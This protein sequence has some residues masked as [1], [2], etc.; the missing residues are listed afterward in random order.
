[1]TRE[2]RVSRAMV[3]GVIGVVLISAL[4]LTVGL[5]AGRVNGGDGTSL[6]GGVSTGLITVLPWAIVLMVW[7]GYRQM[8]ELGQRRTQLASAVAFVAVMLLAGTSYPL[9]QALKWPALPGFAYWLAGWAVFGV[10]T[11]TMAV[12]DK[13]GGRAE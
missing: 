4:G 10:V 2:H 13:R 6:L 8:D 7:R 1:M 12:A 3:G 5:L 11:V 9:Q